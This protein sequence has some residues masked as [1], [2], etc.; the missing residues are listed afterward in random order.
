MELNVTNLN[1]SDKEE[2]DL[3]KEYLTTAD[4][5]VLT[6]FMNFFEDAKDADKLEV[7]QNIIGVDIMVDSF[8]SEDEL[9][10]NE[11]MM[12]FDTDDLSSMV[13]YR[14]I[15]KRIYDLYQLAIK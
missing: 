12:H 11:L 2:L 1:L 9:I 5:T 6:G 8:N 10:L 4:I 3:S 14:I 15:R 13:V 7:I